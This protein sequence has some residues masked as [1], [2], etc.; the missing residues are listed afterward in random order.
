MYS[1]TQTG[2]LVALAGLLATVLN[3]FNVNITSDELQA[4][5]GAAAILVGVVTS[6]VGRYKKGD[7]TIGGFRK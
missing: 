1:T 4:L 7:L 6:W 3:Y 5:I 2:N